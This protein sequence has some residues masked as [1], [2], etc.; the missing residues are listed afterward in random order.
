M[1]A[2]FY[3]VRDTRNITKTSAPKSGSFPHLIFGD[4]FFGENA[5]QTERDECTYQHTHPPLIASSHPIF[6]YKPKP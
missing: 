2:A 6:T 1:A 5:P 3:C 4:F